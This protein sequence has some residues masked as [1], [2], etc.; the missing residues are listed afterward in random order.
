MTDY[1]QI[2]A[3]EKGA[4]M[5]IIA[6]IVLSIIKLS[7][8]WFSNSEALFA[9]GFNNSTD[10]IAS[11]AILIGL[12]ISRRPPDDD[13]LYGHFRAETVASLI[14]SF[15]MIAVGF[16]ILYQA[17][18]HFFAT[19]KPL[20][21]LVA[22]WTAL[23]CAFVMLLVYRYNHR[24]AKKLNSKALQAAAKDNLSDT[25]VSVG[26]FVGI[27]GSHFGLPLLDPIAAII[28]S[29]FVLKT[30]WG[31]FKEAVLSLTDGFDLKLIKA[32]EK[33]VN[34]IPGVEE[35]KDIRARF[36]GN[37]VFVDLT[38]YVMADLNVTESHEISD[39]VENRLQEEHQVKQVHV[40]I[41]P[42]E[43]RKI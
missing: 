30:G 18:A 31:I 38:V 9:D 33:T 29:F 2:K 22:A 8:G 26:A 11:L 35:V 28:V 24:L 3:G 36:Q 5:S 32:F 23:G 42:F 13:H 16:Q 20:P 1:E 17:S 25:F 34:S 4:W 39:A 37:Q 41:E 21:D 7:I 12:R 27:F 14:A 10:I 43:C 6:Y 40:H 19:S 15:I